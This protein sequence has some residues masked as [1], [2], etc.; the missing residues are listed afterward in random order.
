MRPSASSPVPPSS[1]PASSG[2]QGWV[3][4]TVC[5][6]TF[7][8]F[9]DSSI[10]NVSLPSMTASLHTD[11]AT[12]SWVSTAYLLAIV[13][14]LLPVGKLADR[15][16]PRRV[17][18]TGLA[19]FTLASLL[20]AL[21]WSAPILI[22]M[23]VLQGLGAAGVMAIG[24]AL[25]VRTFPPQERGRAMGLVLAAVSVG[26]ISGPVLGGLLTD[27]FGWPAIFLVNLP[28]GLLALGLTRLSLRVAAARGPAA[29]F[30]WLGALLTVGITVPLLWGLNQSAYLGWLHPSVLTPFALALA[31]LGLFLRVESRREQPLL[32]LGIFRRRTLSTSLASASAMFAMGSTV[33]FSLPFF[34]ERVQ[35]FSPGQVGVLLLPVPLTMLFVAPVAGRLSDRVGPRWPTTL[36]ALC[37]LLGLL[38]LTTLGANAA[39]W[40]IIP[41]Q[42]LLGLAIG[43]F[44]APNNAAALSAAPATASGLVGGLVALVR[45]FGFAL[46]A[47]LGGAV[48]GA[49]PTID[50]L[51]LLWALGAALA[52][53][54]LALSFSARRPAPVVAPA[55]VGEAG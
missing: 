26:S 23:R 19:L 44:V 41:R 54:G 34:L 2:R 31:C 53:C 12:I 14:S 37:G 33:T 24:P 35:G 38:W 18:Q 28:L 17:Y 51:H 42:V 15:I 46:G 32:P 22:A 49:S 48:L 25:I 55:Q 13:G 43:L 7:M 39:L 20:C 47:A 3:L 40:E 52:L 27:L 11:V 10:V 29:R 6:G 8:A 50:G 36:G 30:D 1:V 21:A 9:L 45:N 5:L 4:L 16:G